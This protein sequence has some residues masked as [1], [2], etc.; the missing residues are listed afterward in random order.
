MTARKCDK[1]GRFFDADDSVV[2]VLNGE[3]GE[4]ER[5]AHAAMEAHALYHVR[6]WEEIAA[7]G[8][9][10][11]DEEE[12]DPERLLRLRA[13]VSKERAGIGKYSEQGTIVGNPVVCHC[14]KKPT[15]VPVLTCPKCYRSLTWE[16]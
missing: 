13:I 5:E 2:L 8:L 3:F 4:V 12:E 16:A 15:S 14:C 9:E 1:C 7:A 11:C 10:V 6:C